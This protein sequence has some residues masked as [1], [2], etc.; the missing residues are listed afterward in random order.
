MDEKVKLSDVHATMVKLAEQM[1]QWA[2]TAKEEP[3]KPA[4]LAILFFNMK[5]GYKAVDGARKRVYHVVD[6]VEKYLMPKVMEDNDLDMIR[7]PEIAR[8]FS[9]RNQLSA[10]MIDKDEAMKWLRKEGHGD[11]IQETVNSSTL[12]SFIK[13]LIIDEGIDPPEEYFKVS[14]YK[15]T[16]INKYTPK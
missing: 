2:E 8:S 15:T 14:Q 7:V 6:M 1:E 3:P 12:S 4:E 11:L 13:S 10:S 9:L 16:G 5:E